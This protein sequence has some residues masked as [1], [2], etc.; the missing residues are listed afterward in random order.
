MSKFKKIL[1]SHPAHAPEG[2]CAPV[3]LAALFA[4]LRDLLRS[5]RA[6][7]LWCVIPIPLEA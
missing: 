1:S 5:F 2:S 6:R 3:A 4:T 7:A